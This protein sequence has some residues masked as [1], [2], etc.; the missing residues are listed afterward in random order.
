MENGL[1]KS[2]ETLKEMAAAA[3][4]AVKAAEEA[5][6]RK[7]YE[8]ATVRAAAAREAAAAKEKAERLA[9]ENELIAALAAK[10][11][12]ATAGS[13]NI[14]VE[15]ADFGIRVETHYVGG[16]GK[17]TLK[18]SVGSYG[19]CKAYFAGK[20]S[21]VFNYEGI[22]NEVASRIEAK[23][24]RDKYAAD[25][26]ANRDHNREIIKRI[27]VSFKSKF[28]SSYSDM[29]VLLTSD[30]PKDKVIFRFDHKAF[31]EEEAGK[32]LEFLVSLKGK[33]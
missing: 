32:L 31:T 28:G 15:G 4:A 29:G 23:A 6:R 14:A 25:I 27:S 9:V 21:G 3:A 20:K 10:G 18:I 26:E 24:A 13:Y 2:L 12:R 11:M 7:E 8:A 1:P 30:G 22:A 33:E 17:K 19:N 16:Y 5:E